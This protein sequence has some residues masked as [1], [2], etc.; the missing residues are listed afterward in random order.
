M[1]FNTKVEII[2]RDRINPKTN[3]N[4]IEKGYLVRV[5]TI[6][7]RLEII[8]YFDTYHLFSSKYLNYLSWKEGLDLGIKKEHQTIDG[9]NKLI[10]TSMNSNRTKF[11]WKH[12]S[13]FFFYLIILRKINI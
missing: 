6:H 5:R 7:S 9:T 12:L 8:K 13:D 2:S 1:G 10:K 4:Y 3:T 11:Y